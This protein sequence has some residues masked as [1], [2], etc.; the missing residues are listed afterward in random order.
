MLAIFF[1][2]SEALPLNISLQGHLLMKNL[3]FAFRGTKEGQKILALAVS[4]V[5]L[6]QN[7]HCDEVAYSGAYILLPPSSSDALLCFK[8]YL[9]YF[10]FPVTF[11][12]IIAV[13]CFIIIAHFFL[14]QY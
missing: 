12:L 5:I 1:L 10:Q 11:L 14:L 13:F 4:Q 6:I 2:E 9:S 8:F 3:L 7:N